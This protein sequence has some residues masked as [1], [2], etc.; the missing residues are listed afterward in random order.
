MLPIFRRMVARITKVF[1]LQIYRR[2]EERIQPPVLAT[3]DCLFITNNRVTHGC[4]SI[5][6]VTRLT[7]GHLN[8]LFNNV[9]HVS[10]TVHTRTFLTTYPILQ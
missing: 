6:T 8:R 2:I 9:A 3:R 7:M 1:A 10:S 4:N 5:V